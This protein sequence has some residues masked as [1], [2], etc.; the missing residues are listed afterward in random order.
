MAKNVQ[1]ARVDVTLNG[2]A[3]KNELRTMKEQL[4]GFNKEL[5]RLQ[6][7][8]VGAMKPGEVQKMG[9]LRKETKKLEKQIKATED[10]TEAFA[11]TLK[12]INGA[13]LKDLQAAARRLSFEVKE[14]TPGTQQFIEK[15]KQLKDVNTRIVQLRTTFKGLV[16]EEKNATISLKGL[17]DSF[18]K[19][20]GMVTAGI[21]AITGMSMAFRKAAQDAA[22]MDD[23]YAQVRKTTGLT[24]EEVEQLNEAFKKMDTRTS[25]EELNKMAYEA[26]KLGYTGVENI[27]QFVEAA[28]VINV[29]LGDVLGEG[30]TLEIAK[31]AQVFAQSTAVLDNLDLKGKMLAVGS[32]VNQL[33]KESTAS[34]SYMVDFL[35]RLGGVATQA[36]ISADQILGYASALDQMKQKVE[37]SATA[38]Q[39]LIQQM[40][41]KPEE[42]VEAA[43]MPLEEFQKLMET[44]MNGAIKRV[45]EGFNQMGGFTQLVPVFKDMG[46]DGARAAS[47][48]AALAANL[49]KVSEAQATANEHLRLGTSMT[50]EYEIM[51]SSLQARLEKARK[52]FKDASIALGQSLNPIMLKTTKAT[53]YLIKALANY[54]KEIKAAIISIAAFTAIIKL[55]TIAHTAYNV[56]VKAGNVLMATWKTITWAVRV[57]FYKLIGATEAATIA[58]AELNA[59]MSS[60]VF[61]L[62]A[63]AIAAA[64][65]AIVNYTKKTKEASEVT[66]KLEEIQDRI[67]TEYAEEA[68]KVQVL[69]DI[70]HNNNLELDQR[71]QALEKLKEIVPAYHADLT[72]EGQLINDNTEALSLYLKNLEKVT[73]AKILEDEFTQATAAVLKAEQAKRDAEDR[74]VQALLDANGNTTEMTHFT[75]QSSAGAYSVSEITPYG[76]AV[77]D[78]TAA[79]EELTNAQEIQAKIRQRIERENG[80]AFATRKGE[81][82]AE[83]L[84]IRSLNQEYQQLFHTIREE[85]VD[86]PEKAA[87]KIAD[88]QRELRKKIAEIRQKYKD[89]ASTNEDPGGGGGGTVSSSSSTKTNSAYQEELKALKHN[90]Q[91]RQNLTKQLYVEGQITKEQYDEKLLEL[92]M[93]YLERQVE[94]AREYGEDET[95]VMQAFLDAQIAANDRAY[96]EMM[97]MKEDWEAANQ[98]DF[99]RWQKEFEE[100]QAQAQEIKDK[101]HPKDKINSDFANELSNLEKL[102]EAKL[103]SEEDYLAAVDDLHKKH[104][105]DLLDEDLGNIAG[106]IEKANKMFSMA[107]DFIT[108]LKESE[109][110]QL[111]AEYQAQLTAAGDNAEQREAIEAEYEQ[112]KLDLQ[113]KYADTEM[114]INIAKAIAAG[115]LAAIEAFAAAG[116]PILG[117]VFAAIIAATTAL[118]VA[119]IVKQRNAIK[120][121]S[122]SGGGSSSAPK[123]GERKMTGYA[124]GG[125]TEDHTTLTTVGEKGRE[126]VGPAW[127]VRKNPVM[128]ANLERYRK[129]G[130]HGRSGSVSSGFA[131]GGFTPGNGGGQSGAMPAQIDI[132]A[133][134]EAAI[135]R[136]MEDGAI[137]AYVVRKDIEEL[138]AQTLKFKKLGSR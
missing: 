23:A 3:A 100:L 124:E 75:M 101:L 38:F 71:R 105:Q 37:M 97:K 46:L 24:R 128:F 36:G 74:R 12:N 56:V 55:N 77:R 30:A 22:A 16:A 78:V 27:R 49:D 29:A 20:F 62:I 41:K 131:D 70:V 132:E 11:R 107:S 83:E 33:G 39:K 136:V 113:K 51:N 64:T 86:N 59:V 40:I 21:A 110:A 85:N 50:R 130:S 82:T 61:V 94:L 72:K 28:D 84:E 8:P 68:S 26:G 127:M 91:E 92:D 119:T 69:T 32:A 66:K 102:H 42:F 60:N 45:L 125:Y 88:F 53:T 73:R 115:A 133:A 96:A 98:K 10:K 17:A 134:V 123:T 57:G 7:T 5:L 54:G 31:L 19:Y 116:N 117:A 43:R 126:W 118:E 58:Q 106:Y 44:D 34:E 4:E 63:T 48:I 135:R 18:N 137:R 52:E 121:T 103:L 87:E 122:V 1:E 9:E 2:E 67:N 95:Q 129:A 114:V 108:A 13:S 99:E 65:V 109:S 14:L 76:Q 15:S 90:L 111:E 80:D 112:K 93:K 104:N 120:N 25:R 89:A 81:L 6:K 138:D 35:G 79:T 47:V